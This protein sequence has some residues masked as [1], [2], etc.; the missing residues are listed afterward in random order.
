M[1][2]TRG[3]GEAKSVVS[4]LPM[5]DSN[6]AVRGTTSPIAVP[7]NASVI[8]SPARRHERDLTQSVKA[9][10]HTFAGKMR[11]DGFGGYILTIQD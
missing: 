2:S 10:S 8:E 4:V 6:P 5:T 11:V 9:S 3:G 1:A 7:R